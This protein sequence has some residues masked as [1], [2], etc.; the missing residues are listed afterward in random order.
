[1]YNWLVKKM[2]ISMKLEDF[3]RRVEYIPKQTESFE[4]TEINNY[5]QINFLEHNDFKL[6]LL[7]TE[8]IENFGNISSKS[9]LG[10]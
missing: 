1:M 5:C 3:S 7:N 4:E 2:S 6:V 8:G 10:C 9:I